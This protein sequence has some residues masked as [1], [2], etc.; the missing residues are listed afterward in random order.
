[1]GKMHTLM[2]ISTH[3]HIWMM[4]NGQFVQSLEGI[5]IQ[6]KQAAE[7]SKYTKESPRLLFPMV[8]TV[9]VNYSPATESGEF[10]HGLLL[11]Q[12]VTP[13]PT[14]RTRWLLSSPT[15]SSVPQAW[16]LHKWVCEGV[17]VWYLVVI[18]V[19]YSKHW[20]V[21]VA[22]VICLQLRQVATGLQGCIG[23]QQKWS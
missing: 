6:S 1:M 14:A 2:L 22:C 21:M 20:N 15:F 11:R 4:I 5:C 16:S 3:T 12:Q 10:Q 23:L 18:Y 13:P 17:G 19:H 7:K 9:L 8:Y